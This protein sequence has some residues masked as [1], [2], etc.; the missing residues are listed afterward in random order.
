[1]SMGAGV[2]CGMREDYWV[3]QVLNSGTRAL[4]MMMRSGVGTARVSASLPMGQT[5]ISL[6]A[7]WAT[8]Y[9][10]LARKKR[11][12]SSCSM[13]RSRGLSM[14]CCCPPIR[15]TRVSLSSI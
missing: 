9:G 6:M 8:L 11:A 1:M 10:R 2:P 3:Y 15:R 4:L 13:M 5:E 7:R 12:G 14:V